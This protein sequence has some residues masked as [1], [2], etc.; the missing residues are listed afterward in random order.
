MIC[1]TERTPFYLFASLLRLVFRFCLFL[2]LRQ[3]PAVDFFC[4][5]LFSIFYSD[6]RKNSLSA[7]AEIVSLKSAAG[8]DRRSRAPHSFYVA[9][10]G[11]CWS[12]CRFF[13]CFSFSFDIFIFKK[14]VFKHD[15]I[16]SCKE[17]LRG[18]LP[19][20]LFLKNTSQLDTFENR[21]RTN[22]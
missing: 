20:I 21:Q 6:T 10:F 5:F 1:G 11:L 14:H 12:V 15:S 4:V 22:S 7:L 8:S 17:L 18:P 9:F 3:W 13:L 2:F 19:I 16:S